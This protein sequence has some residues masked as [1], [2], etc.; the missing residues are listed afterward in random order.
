MSFYKGYIITSGKK[1]ME[2]FKDIDSFPNSYEDCL[3]RKSFAG[4]MAKDSVFIDFDDT[5]QAQIALN[6]VKALK[7]RCRVIKT[8]RGS[9][10]LFKYNDKIKSCKTKT[11]IAVG[12][13]CDI[14]G[15]FTNAVEV[16]KLDGV[17]RPVIYDTGE[18]YDIVPKMFLPIVTNIKGLENYSNGSG[19]NDALY[20]YIL[21]LKANGYSKDEIKDIYQIINQFVLKEPLSD[22]ELNTILRDESFEKQVNIINN[23]DNDFFNKNVFLFDK[24]AKY[25]IDKYNIKII[26]GALHIYQDNYYQS[27]YKAIEKAMISEIPVLSKSKRQEVLSYLEIIADNTNKI[28]CNYICF[29]NGVY[30]IQNDTLL[31]HSPKYIITNKIPHNYSNTQSCVVDTMM[32]NISCNN[33][34]LINLLYEMAG[35]TLYSRNEFAKA[36]ILV[37]QGSNG[38]STFL[39]MI[40]HMLGDYNFSSLD[41]NK[42]DD[43]FSTIMLYNKLA[44][45][46]DD[47]S[48]SFIPDMALFKKIVT[49]ETINAEQKGQPKIDFNPFCKI[50]LSA[51]NIPRMGKGRDTYA[52]SRRLMIIPFNAH[53]DQNNDDY[54]QFI[55]DE[56]STEQA[57]EHLIF[58]A[59]KALRNLLNNKCKFT[60]IDLVNEQIDEFVKDNNPILSFF[61]EISDINNMST[62]DVYLQYAV[63]CNENGFQKINKNIFVKECIKFFNVKI[64]R[65]REN[66]K[67]NKI[68]VA[69]NL[70]DE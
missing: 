30:D 27:S 60:S 40:K 16:L 25:L 42:L 41:L 59:V 19:R 53:F 69:K 35:T 55:A 39:T 6:I 46:S 8:K 54:N 3:K 70:L 64:V 45:I 22:N 38:K 62:D 5:A 24:F 32:K 44:N 58:N 52:I 56:L 12:L 47:M 48:D 66:Y 13:N 67:I 2:K 18:P 34:Q 33:Q 50:L 14:K 61:D 29:N 49:G 4:V 10:F 26:N 63:F 36:F 31:E 43:R 57:I 65:K 9:H 20:R 51:N 28:N 21:V 15:G 17:L 68:F 23:F 7:L 1:P 37:G 11:P